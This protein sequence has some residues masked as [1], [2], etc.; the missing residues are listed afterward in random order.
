MIPLFVKT[1]ETDRQLAVGGSPGMKRMTL[2]ECLSLG[3]PAE[4]SQTLV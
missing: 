3:T 4:M 2:G 1:Y